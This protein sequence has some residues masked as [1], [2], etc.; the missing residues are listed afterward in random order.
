[1]IGRWYIWSDAGVVCKWRGIPGTSDID[2]N[3]RRTNASFCLSFT[4]SSGDGVLKSNAT[5]CEATLTSARE[6]CARSHSSLHCA[7]TEK[8]EWVRFAFR[9][10][11]FVK[12]EHKAT[13]K[14]DTLVAKSFS[15]RAAERTGPSFVAVDAGVECFAAS[16]DRLTVG[17]KPRPGGGFRCLLSE[18]DGCSKPGGGRWVG[19]W[20]LGC[21][22]SVTSGLWLLANSDRL[23]VPPVCG[24]LRF[25]KLPPRRLIPGRGSTMRGSCCRSDS[26]DSD[27][28]PGTLLATGSLLCADA[29]CER[30]SAGACGGRAACCAASADSELPSRDGELLPTLCCAAR[31]ARETVLGEEALGTAGGEALWEAWAGSS[32]LCDCCRQLLLA[33]ELFVLWR[34]ASCDRLNTWPGCDVIFRLSDSDTCCATD[35]GRGWLICKAAEA[36]FTGFWG[37]GEDGFSVNSSYLAW[38]KRERIESESGQKHRGTN[39]IG[40]QQDSMKT[41]RKNGNALVL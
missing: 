41:N 19:M 13:A 35:C 1:M 24:L 27:A 6:R 14:L 12:L 8:L 16:S 22:A 28:V 38:A 20:E 36:C 37:G 3:S 10:V 4:T 18:V 17:R 5:T 7:N 15:A 33:T 40:A 9:L 30:D 29:S 2:A 31:W 39:P 25:E 34:S 23:N 32:E 21:A 11:F 26:C